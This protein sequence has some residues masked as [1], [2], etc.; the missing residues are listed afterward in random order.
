MSYHPFRFGVVAAQARSGDEWIASARRAEAWGY[1]TWLIP[2]TLGPTLAP[3][4]ALAVMAAATQSIRLGTFVLAN[5]FRNPVHVARE[6]ATLDLLSSGRFELGLGAG[7]PG[8]VDDYRALGISADSGGVRV[9]RLAES[10]GVIKALLSGQRV[11]APGPYY[12]IADAQAFPQTF[13]QPRPP[14]LVAGSGKRLLALA[15]RE[16]DIVA[17]GARPDETAAAVAEKVAWLR[18]AA[19]NRFAQLELNINLIAVGDPS[20]QPSRARYGLDIDIAQMMRNAS[21]FVLMGRPDDMRDQL[22]QRR[23]AL[24]VSYITVGADLM[25]R[26]APVVELLTGR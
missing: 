2:D 21:P 4:P 8:A 1:A 11:S 25:E 9:E 16:A 23:E 24:G 3:M 22:L 26:F 20:H 13:Q 18:E 6:S 7:R 12:A 5:D 14:I 19:G 10:L 15:A 17:L